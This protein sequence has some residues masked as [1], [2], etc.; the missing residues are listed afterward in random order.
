MN[1]PRLLPAAG[2]PAMAWKNGGGITHQVSIAPD[3]ATLDDFDWRVSFADVASDGP[4]SRFPGIARSLAILTGGGIDLALPDGTIRLAAGGPPTHFPGGV[5]AAAKLVAGAVRDLNVMSRRRRFAHRLTVLAPGA[6]D[7]PP[8]AADA[9]FLLSAGAWRLDG[10][11]EF[12]AFDALR[13]GRTD[14]TG[15]RAV[16]AAAPLYRIELSAIASPSP[17]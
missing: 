4:F 10:T 13:F 1:G 7:L 8:V 16:T 17:G 5:P 15:R 9:E 6:H 3:G 11:G 2:H 12:A 14:E